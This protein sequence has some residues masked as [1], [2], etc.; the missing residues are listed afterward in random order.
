MPRKIAIVG[1]R[2]R[3]CRTAV[4]RLVNRLPEGTVVVSGG[5]YGV[6]QWAEATARLRGLRVKI[7][8]PKLT[9]GARYPY[10]Q[11]VK[12]MYARN[13]KV[14][15]YADE[16]YA[17]VAKDRTGGTENTL[18]YFKQLRKRVHLC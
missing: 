18:G 2:R 1:S 16:V 5:C 12:A 14:A 4:V 17:F 9:P 7:F 11:I 15:Q 3:H 8:R 6:D 10:H 13:L